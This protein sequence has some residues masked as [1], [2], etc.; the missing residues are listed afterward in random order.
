MYEKHFGLKKRPFRA[1]ATGTDVFVGPQI[2]AAMAGLKK[3]LTTYDSVVTVAGPVGSGKTTLVNRALE[4][5][6]GNRKTVLIPRMR[7]DSNDVL[8]FLLDDLGVQDRPNGTIQRFALFRRHL[9]DLA[10]N[11]TRVCIA[12]ED[13]VRLGADTLAEVEALTAADTGES[14]GAS[15]V[16]M[17]DEA[18]GD[19]LR[20]SPLER[21]QQRIRQR[22][23]IAAFPAAELRGYLR[24]SFRL[25][26]RDFEQVFE[27]NAAEMLHHLSDGIPRIANNLVESDDCGR[28]SGPGSCPDHVAGPSR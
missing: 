2:A 21:I 19:M 4:S 23:S 28:R 11:D 8:E 9:K 14:D 3:A 1:N 22:L 15:L 20:E 10:A 13:S 17:G 18:L 5:L 6:A 24:H 26:G 12:I 25:A 16:L 27:A 7:L